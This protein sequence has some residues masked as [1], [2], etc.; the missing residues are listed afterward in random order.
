VL[1]ITTLRSLCERTDGS[2]PLRCYS[3]TC[4]VRYIGAVGERKSEVSAFA[5][6]QP[7]LP[8]IALSL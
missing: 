7:E 5:L 1:D 4:V 2:G 3:D 8:G 6:V